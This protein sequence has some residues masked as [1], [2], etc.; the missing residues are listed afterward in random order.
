MPLTGNIGND[1]SELKDANK[2]KPA[3]KKRPL[4]QIIAIALRTHRRL[5]GFKR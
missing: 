1:I 5:G 4:R 3:N 2:S